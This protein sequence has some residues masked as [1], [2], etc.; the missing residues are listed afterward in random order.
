MLRLEKLE[1]L[2]VQILEQ[3]QQEQLEEPPLLLLNWEL[4]QYLE[5]KLD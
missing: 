2:G 5:L 1:E 3:V 4:K